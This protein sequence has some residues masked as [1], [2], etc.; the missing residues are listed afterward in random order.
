[1]ANITH[2]RTHST[3]DSEIGLIYA[4]VCPVIKNLNSEAT[5]CL[6]AGSLVFVTVSAPIYTV[7]SA[8]LAYGVIPCCKVMLLHLQVDGDFHDKNSG[9][10]ILVRLEV[11][12]N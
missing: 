6:D 4:F 9:V 8:I 5:S 11:V 10:Y 2:G 3:P 1:M 7:R 12:P